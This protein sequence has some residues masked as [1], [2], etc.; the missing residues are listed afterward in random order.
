MTK[1]DETV[2]QIAEP[3]KSKCCIEVSVNSASPHCIISGPSGS[4]MTP[5]W[6]PISWGKD[7]EMWIEKKEERE[8]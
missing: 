3:L 6:I 7:K 8:N 5:G 2:K 1:H 4:G